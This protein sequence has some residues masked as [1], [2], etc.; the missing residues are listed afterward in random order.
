MIKF[1]VPGESQSDFLDYELLIS[2][3]TQG[4]G[5]RSSAAG[6]EGMK[7][8]PGGLR[9]AGKSAQ[10]IDEEGSSWV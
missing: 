4:G 3:E 2:V 6:Q 10:V 9:S 5:C 1:M 7:M 8:Y